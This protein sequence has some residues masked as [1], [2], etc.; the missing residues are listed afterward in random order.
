MIRSNLYKKKKSDEFA[1]I[2][3]GSGKHL[4]LL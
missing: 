3:H 1:V 4:N 2:A